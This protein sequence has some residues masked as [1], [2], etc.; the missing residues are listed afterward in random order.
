MTE[1]S[2]VTDFYGRWAGLYDLLATRTPGIRGVR[3]RTVDALGLEPG[4]TVVEVGCGTGANFPYLR[5][6]V[7]EAGQVVGVDLTPGMLARAGDRI[8]RAGWGN[9][10][11]LRGDATRPPVTRADAVLGTF[12]VGM[13]EDP[14]AAVERWAD[15][16]GPGGRI[17]LLDAGPRERSSPLDAA[18]RLFVAASAPPTTRLRYAESPARRLGERVA[19]AREALRSRGAPVV[20]ER[21]GRGFLRLTSSRVTGPGVGVE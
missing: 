19:A 16:V 3:D 9:V 13:F 21:F 12:V 5:D 4:D 14:A 7:G 20:D 6:G 2:A 11:V 15:V 8:E 10:H 17:A 18:F 1:A